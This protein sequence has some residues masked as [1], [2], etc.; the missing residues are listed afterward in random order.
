M[1][2]CVAAGKH[3]STYLNR[4]R[5]SNEMTTN[6]G[7]RNCTQTHTV[8]SEIHTPLLRGMLHIIMKVVNSTAVLVPDRNSLFALGG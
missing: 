8:Y 4:N 7:L 3:N 2:G 6:I 5:A 1:D